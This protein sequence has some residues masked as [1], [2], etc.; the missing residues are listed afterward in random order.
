M[1]KWKEMKI[2]GVVDIKKCVAEFQV[3]ELKYTPW[4]YFKVKIYENNQG[5]FTGYTNLML[6]DED[7]CS[8]GGVGHG[9]TIEAALEDTILYFI[10]MLREK[11]NLSDED[12]E[13]ADPYDF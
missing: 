3:S 11:H 4:G 13:A 5:S 8:F 12:F 9:D 10:K 2:L 7:N 6:K 1:D